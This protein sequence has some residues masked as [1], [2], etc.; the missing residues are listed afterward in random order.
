MAIGVIVV[1]A[2]R[3]AKIRRSPDP[4]ARYERGA[5][6]MVVLGVLIY[7]F[8]PLVVALLVPVLSLDVPALIAANRVGTGIAVACLLGALTVWLLGLR[9]R[10]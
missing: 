2:V 1:C 8:T 4:A 7:W 6:G 10:R 3:W 9:Q 5:L